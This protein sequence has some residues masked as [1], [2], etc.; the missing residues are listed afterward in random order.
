MSKQVIGATA[1]QV[2][3]N[4]PY[5]RKFTRAEIAEILA[6][7]KRLGD[8][9]RDG[10]APSGHTLYIPGDI[11]EMW[12]VHGALAGCDVDQDAAFI[13]AR[14]LPDASGA[15]SMLKHGF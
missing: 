3:P 5:D 14:K 6:K 9:M 2:F 10:L 4:F 1:E 11:F 7:A 13:R 15:S 12:M 8:A